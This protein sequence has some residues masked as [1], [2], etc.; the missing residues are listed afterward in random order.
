MICEKCGHVHKAGEIQIL[1]ADAIIDA[2]E[3]NTGV[4]LKQIKSRSRYREISTARFLLVY[5]LKKHTNIVHSKMS[6]IVGKYDHTSSMHA[7]KTIQNLLD[8][9]DP[10]VSWMHHQISSQLS[11]YNMY[12]EVANRVSAVTF[13]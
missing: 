7:C 5:F 12:E 9:K 6:T 3:Q 1:P 8:V 11:K 10:K 2:V 13:Y 4:K